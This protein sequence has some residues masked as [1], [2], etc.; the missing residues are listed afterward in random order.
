MIPHLDSPAGVPRHAQ[1]AGSAV[2]LH[3]EAAEAPGG[4]EQRGVRQGGAEGLLLWR[5]GGKGGGGGDG[6]GA[7]LQAAVLDEVG[8][9]GHAGHNSRC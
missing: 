6:G 9:R 4:G 8:E 7:G 1:Q 5:R 3:R 2:A